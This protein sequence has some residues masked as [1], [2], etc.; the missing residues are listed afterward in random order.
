MFVESA[1][2]CRQ[3]GAAT[4]SGALKLCPK[5]SEKL[6]R[7]EHC[8]APLDDRAG[9]LPGEKASAG[10]VARRVVA[11]AANRPAWR[12]A[13]AA[14][15]LRR[16]QSR[17]IRT[18]RERTCRADGSTACKSAIPARPPRGDRDGCSTTGGSCRSGKSTTTIARPGDRSIGSAPRRPKR[19]STAGCRFLRGKRRARGGNCRRR[20]PHSPPAA[21]VP[22]PLVRNRQDRQRQTRPRARRAVYPHSFAGQS[23][24]G[25][26]VARGGD[27][28][29]VGAAAVRAAV[30]SPGQFRPTWSGPAE[31]YWFKFQAVAPGTT[32]I[33]LIYV[34]PWEKGQAPADA[35]QI[36][37]EAL[38]P[39]PL[40]PHA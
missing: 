11:G 4:A 23:D 17:S 28:R 15:S 16:R 39:Q 34:R 3:C 26:P 7:C 37:V 38:A 32:K 13:G 2:V 18:S 9:P 20:P 5:C 24:H 33:K 12:D 6:H 29:S 10:A 8:L 40:P 27:R 36:T 1:G 19:A 30:C 22:I 21:G 35:F 31:S 14:R 25:L